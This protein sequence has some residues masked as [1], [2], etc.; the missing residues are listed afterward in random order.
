M[1]NPPSFVFW[2]NA[3][4]NLFTLEPARE[5]SF[6]KPLRIEGIELP[7]YNHHESLALGEW[8]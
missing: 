5:R 7:M 8:F 4:W 3:T 1:T 6:S 2:T